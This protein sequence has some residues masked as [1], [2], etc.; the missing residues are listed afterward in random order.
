MAI[1]EEEGF[2]ALTIARL[3]KRAD[4]AVGALYRYFDSKDALL[5]ALQIRA[6]HRT[7]EDV[8]EDLKLLPPPTTPGLALAR[9]ITALTSWSRF[10]VRRPALFA[11]IDWSLSA[12]QHLLQDRSAE[13]V[14]V[15]FEPLLALA[16]VVFQDAV[17]A[18][19][20]EGGP[21]TKRTYGAWALLHGVGHF[22]KRD[23]LLP[24]PLQATRVFEQIF[25]DLLEA[26]GAN[27]AHTDEAIQIY[28]QHFDTPKF[29]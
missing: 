23:R 13:R 27:T 2:D 20:L 21:Y 25:R 5:T 28:R 10:R 12:P 29:S 1:I 17:K 24:A 16:V 26:W 14:A 4:A 9:A 15:A 8:Q 22:Q 18:G 6:A 3:A 11:L 19:A 7:L